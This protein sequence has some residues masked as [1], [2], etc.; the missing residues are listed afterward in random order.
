M[1]Y[2]YAFQSFAALGGR[3]ISQKYLPFTIDPVMY[4]TGAQHL[5]PILSS[6]ALLRNVRS[7]EG[8]RVYK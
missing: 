6:H 8:I 5:L 1:V 3:L 2:E 7:F 4:L